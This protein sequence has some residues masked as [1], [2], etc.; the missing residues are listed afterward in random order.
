MAQAVCC[1]PR[2]TTRPV[3]VGIIVHKVALR[4]VLPCTIQASPVS[5][6][7]SVL[8]TCVSFMYN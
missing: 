4:Q 6:I 8:H 2:F 7:I 3:C 5:S 1:Q